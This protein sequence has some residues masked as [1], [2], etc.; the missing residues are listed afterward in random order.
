MI[1][2]L[3]HRVHSDLEPKRIL[4]PIEPHRVRGWT[5]LSNILLLVSPSGSQG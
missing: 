4:G 2:H 3:L 1:L 5:I